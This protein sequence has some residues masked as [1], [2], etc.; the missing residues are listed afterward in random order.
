MLPNQAVNR[1][2]DILEAI[3]KVQ[4]YA[5]EDPDLSQKVVL[6]AVSY[7]LAVI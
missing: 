1:I 7:N 5:N 6:E 4:E 3:E 2:K